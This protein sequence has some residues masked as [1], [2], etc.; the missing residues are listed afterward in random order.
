MDLSFF[1][2]LY[3]LH[4]CSWSNKE[5]KLL[6]IFLQHLKNQQANTNKPPAENYGKLVKKYSS[7]NIIKFPGIYNS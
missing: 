4:G 1:L 5:Q 2:D 7:N 3:F 6:A